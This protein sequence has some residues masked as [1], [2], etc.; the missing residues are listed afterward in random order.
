MKLKRSMAEIVQGGGFLVL[1]GHNSTS[2]ALSQR[3]SGKILKDVYK[4]ARLHGGMAP[5][6]HSALSI[7][8]ALGIMALGGATTTMDGEKMVFHAHCP[9]LHD[10]EKYYQEELNPLTSQGYKSV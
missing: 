3:F 2:G 8:H 1:S 9:A 5:H 7:S 6:F 4:L 10:F